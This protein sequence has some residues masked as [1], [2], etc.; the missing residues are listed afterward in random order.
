MTTDATTGS[1]RQN[2]IKLITDAAAPLDSPAA[3]DELLDHV[4]VALAVDTAT[5]LVVDAHARQL[6]ATA[7]KGLEEEV[8]EGFRVAMG[9]G[10]AGRVAQTRQPLAI[11]D[12][13]RSDV[14]SQI[15]LD[16]GIRSL[17]GVPVLAAGVLVGVL[18]VGTI[19]RREFTETDVKLLQVAADR[20][21]VAGR[22]RSDGMEQAAA[23]ALQRSLLPP[24]LPEVSGVDLAARYVPGHDLGIG[25]D[26]YDVFT[27]P[28]GWIGAVIGDVS[29]HGLRSAVVMGRIRSALRAYALI[30]DDP[31]GVLSMLDRKIHHF[32]AGNLTTALYAMIPPDR[33]TVHISLAGHLRPILAVPGR[34]TGMPPIPVDPPLGIGPA[35]YRR[36]TTVLE[37]PPG[38]ALVCFTDGLVERRA[39]IIDVGLARLTD[40]IDPAPA[41]ELC[42][43]IMLTIG[44]D[45]PTDDVA[46]LAVRRDPA[47]PA[48]TPD[49]P[50]LA[51]DFTTAGLG[52]VRHEIEA[53][54]R[55]TGGLD[56]AELDDWV[57]AINELMVNALRHGGGSGHVTLA[58]TDRLTCEVRDTGAGFAADEYVH[59]ATRPALSPTGG[60]GLWIVG[61]MAE[62]VSIDSGP[63]GTVVRIAARPPETP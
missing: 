58:L 41:E 6:V 57:T 18:H 20:V 25:G 51:V 34:P 16:K 9:Q 49:H 22:I 29:G 37:L 38:A 1:D 13:S 31:A 7:A 10:F 28:S 17:L 63:T 40:V 3:I 55:H 54:S 12:V 48:G 4:R 44:V 32:E 56:D 53:V 19:E 45:Q 5:I 21:S 62:L 60:M 35:R 8:W 2:R 27:L 11:V 24:Q 14:V 30:H 23:L 50:L 39:E 15:L 43:R 33:S 61:R 26:W 46:L 36:R 52:A 47:A 42:A 59:R